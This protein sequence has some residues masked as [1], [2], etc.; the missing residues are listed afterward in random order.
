MPNSP[1]LMSGSEQAGYAQQFPRVPLYRDKR[2]FSRVVDLRQM[3]QERM[4]KR[5]PSGEKTQ[6][7]IIRFD[8][9]EERY[10][11]WFIVRADRT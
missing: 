11:T 6:A 9:R 8:S 1:A 2:H 10:V 4:R 3:G 7:D 5:A